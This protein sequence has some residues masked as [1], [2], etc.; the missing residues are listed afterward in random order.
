MK[1]MT[2]IGSGMV[3]DAIVCTLVTTNNDDLDCDD[4]VSDLVLVSFSLLMFDGDDDCDEDGED[5]RDDN[6]Y[7]PLRYINKATLEVIINPRMMRIVEFFIL[8]QLINMN[9]YD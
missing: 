1:D 6:K 2:L 7:S 3:V 9:L 4:D 5:V 8:L